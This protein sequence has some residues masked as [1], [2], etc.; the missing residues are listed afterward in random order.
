MSYLED[1]EMALFEGYYMAEC[2]H[3]GTRI[4]S[5]PDAEKLYCETCDKVVT[6]GCL[7]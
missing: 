5:E 3:C 7:V 4:K 1:M 6:V 2:P